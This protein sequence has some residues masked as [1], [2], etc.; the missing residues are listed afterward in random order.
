[1]RPM[2]A[3][4]PR[5]QQAHGLARHE[6]V[7]DE[8]GLFNREARVA[9]LQ[10]AGAIVCDALREDEVLR[11][12]G[13]AHRVGLEKPEA[14]NGPL[15]ADRLEQAARDRVAS[16]LLKTE[17]ADRGYAWRRQGSGAHR[18]S[19]TTVKD[20]RTRRLAS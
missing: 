11:A 3:V 9:A 7:I 13:R 19:M 8:E 2:R 10:L 14:R 5:M 20:G 18:A 15:Q 16:N 1:M 12:G 6:T 4:P 17:M